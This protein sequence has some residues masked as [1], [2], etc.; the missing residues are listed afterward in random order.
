MAKRS[1]TDA[2]RAAVYAAL[3][4]S[5]GNVKRSARETNIPISTVRDWKTL[6][7]R[8][9]FPEALQEVYEQVVEDIVDSLQ[10]V[11]DK[12]LLELERLVD[13]H[14]LKGRDLLVAVGMLTDKIRLYKGEATSRSESRMQLPE[15]EEIRQL[16]AGF[17][18]DAVADAQER[19]AEIDDADW[20]PI[21][22][23]ELPA[24]S[25]E[26]ALID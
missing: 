1:Y 12:S 21:P 6:W 15:P 14:E 5:N 9:G 20:E 25:E 8:E 23:R 22:V 16:M 11:R 3:T 4:A 24:P 19:A 2:E 26:V 10:R 7:E 13:N 18:T 17:F